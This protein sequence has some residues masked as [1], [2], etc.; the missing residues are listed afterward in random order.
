MVHLIDRSGQ[1]FLM[2]LNS[3][4]IPSATVTTE[5]IILSVRGDIIFTLFTEKGTEQTAPKMIMGASLQSMLSL[6]VSKYIVTPSAQVT[7]SAREAI[8][9]AFLPSTPE[10]IWPLLTKGPILKTSPSFEKRLFSGTSR[11]VTGTAPSTTHSMPKK[12]QKWKTKTCT[13]P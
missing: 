3:V 5:I 11:E 1:K 8:P 13:A 10:S 9:M 12:Q 6:A 4:T 2:V 7:P